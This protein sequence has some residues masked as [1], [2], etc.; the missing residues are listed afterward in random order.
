MCIIICAT[1]S[2]HRTHMAASRGE[3]TR[4]LAPVRQ[5][6]T[7]SKARLVA[8]LHQELAVLARRYMQHERPNHTLQ[9]TALINEA[10]IRLFGKETPGWQNRAHFLAHAAWAMRQILV[11]HARSRRTDKRGGRHLTI[12]LDAPLTPS[13][14]PL[15]ET[16]AAPSR[17]A[18]VIA[19]DEALT[20]L[21]SFD[22]RQAQIVELR[23]FGG[24]TEV[25]IGLL[26]GV[27]PRTVRRQWTMAR[28]WLKRR[29]GGPLQPE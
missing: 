20:E 16:L 29:L 12:S 24:M 25:D 21:A 18:D 1:G 14:P 3:V 13:G 7:D 17:S 28:L 26:L 10:Y 23:Y 8:L 22:R 9:P 2:E 19:L 5:G 11:D 4:L 27:T 6:E 15:A